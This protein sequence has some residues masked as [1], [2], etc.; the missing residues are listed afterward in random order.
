MIFWLSI[1]SKDLCGYFCNVRKNFGLLFVPTSGHTD[2]S[3]PLPPPLKMSSSKIWYDL[4][5]SINCTST[6]LSI[7]I[8]KEWNPKKD[9][10][11]ILSS[12][13]GR[14]KFSTFQKMSYFEAVSSSSSPSPPPFKQFGRSF[15]NLN[16]FH[17]FFFLSE[18]RSF[19]FLPW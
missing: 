5:A 15:K 18:S 11:N 6:I 10:L 14:N 17:L 3:S 4:F 19:C 2:N 7:F 8:K 9:F 12:P 13:F 1:L 16:V